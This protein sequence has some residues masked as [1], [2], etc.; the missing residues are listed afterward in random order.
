M[1]SKK[2]IRV[3]PHPPVK[4]LRETLDYCHDMREFYDEWTRTDKDGRETNGG[5]GRDD[6]RLFFS[7]APDF[8]VAVSSY[9][10]S[11]LPLM[12]FVENIDEIFTECQTRRIEFADILRT[13]PLWFA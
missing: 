12:W 11:R 9:P 7:E 5:I 4:S 8:V 2:F 6:M 3:N 10:K 1:K 13:H